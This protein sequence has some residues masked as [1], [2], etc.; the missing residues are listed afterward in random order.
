MEYLNQPKSARLPDAP[1]LRRQVARICQ[2][3]RLR[4]VAEPLVHRN[5]EPQTAA[6]IQR[7]KQCSAEA[8]ERC[9]ELG[10]LVAGTLLL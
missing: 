10:G 7:P 9:A 4:P 3:W 2:G 5:G 1:P 6:A 8:R